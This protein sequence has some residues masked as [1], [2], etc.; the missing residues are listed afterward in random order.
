MLYIYSILIFYVMCV[1][2]HCIL[3]YIPIQVMRSHVIH[4][5]RSLNY[6]QICRVVFVTHFSINGVFDLSACP[7]AH[8][9]LLSI[10]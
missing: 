7:T 1:Y 2:T 3:H 4:R 6:H 5:H 8:N 9:Q 10:T